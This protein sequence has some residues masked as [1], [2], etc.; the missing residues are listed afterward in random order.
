MSSKMGNDDTRRLIRD[1]LSVLT[2]DELYR[3]SEEQLDFIVHPITEPCFLKACPGSG[4]TEVVGLKAAFE[5]AD[6]KEDFSGIAILSFTRNA[7]KEIGAR[8]AKYNGAASVRHPHYVGTIDAWLHSYIL[9]PFGHSP[10]RFMPRLRREKSVRLVPN[11][12]AYRYL[13]E[14]STNFNKAGEKGRVTCINDF[15]LNVLGNCESMHDSINNLADDQKQILKSKKEKFFASGWVTY[16]D[17]EYICY[18]VLAAEPFAEL[19]S[20]RFPVV[21][22]DECQDLS[23]SQLAIL[24]VLVSK[25]T[26]VHLVGDVN[27][28]IYEFRRVSIDKLEGFVAKNCLTTKP[29]TRNFR[30]NQQIVDTCQKLVRILAAGKEASPV[31]GTSISSSEAG[32]LV[33]EYSDLSTLPKRFIDFINPRPDISCAQ[34]VILARGHSLLAKFRPSSIRDLNNAGLFAN[35]LLCWNAVGR[36]SKDMLNALQQ[37]GKCISV[38]GWSGSGN[39]TNQFC[40]YGLSEIEWRGTLCG[41]LTDASRLIY[42]YDGKT[43][44]DWTNNN[45]KPFLKSRWLDMPGEPQDW[46]IAK[47]VLRSKPGSGEKLIDNEIHGLCTEMSECIRIT[48]IHDVKGETFDAVMLVSAQDKKGSKTGRYFTE[49]IDDAGK[50]EFVRFAFV[51]SSRPR[52][53]LIWAIPKLSNGSAITK[54]ESF[55]FQK[56]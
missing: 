54:L 32:C 41:L 2:R 45:L 6:W 35:A 48:T 24:H 12:D 39:Q 52:N 47:H 56:H 43:W 46:E 38:L 9:Q 44:A 36:T 29:L 51:A 55:G 30:S 11:D 4:K 50:M 28:A 17:A 42:P 18:K 37:I 25:G 10:M 23:Y 3:L 5:I 27:Q 33:W 49:W 34:S 14:F 31:T 7:A 15:Y 22:V 1:R 21:I 40:P 16:Q 19:L 53:L 8:I 26:R 20:R 13:S